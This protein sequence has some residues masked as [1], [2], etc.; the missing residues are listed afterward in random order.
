MRGYTPVGEAP[1]RSVICCQRRRSPCRRILEGVK[2]ILSGAGAAG[3][4]HSLAFRAAGVDVAA[5]YDPDRSRAEALADLCGARVV[6]SVA[7]LALVP[8]EIASICGPPSVH[9]AQ[10]EVLCAKDRTV[11]IEKPVAVS[12]NELDRL[13]ELPRCVPVIQWRAGRAIRALRRAIL[14]GELGHA[15]VASC[16]LAWGRDAEY[17]RARQ[18]WGC[19]ALLSIGIHAIDAVT[20]AFGDKIAGAAGITTHRDGVQGEVAA[21]ALLRFRHGA[22]A[23]IRI[24]LDGGAD[25]T[26]LMVCG[27][28]VSACI[29]GAEADPTGSAV[30]WYTDDSATRARLEALERETPG[31]LGSPLLVPYIGA[32][33]RALMRE[34]VPGVSEALPSIAETYEAHEAAMCVATKGSVAADS[35]ER[36]SPDAA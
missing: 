34:E 18:T 28:G 24:S 11:F 26:R 1:S 9:V 4:L 17:F 5:I 29:E 13:R 30:R 6:E 20:W 31:A 19:G 23:S 10:A 21:V 16:D 2:A 8:A 7:E 25:R 15:P 3:L 32:A 27:R 12:V 36:L 22:S 33:V 35:S 14:H